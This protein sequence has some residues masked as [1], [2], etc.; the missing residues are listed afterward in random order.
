MLMH[1]PTRPAETLETSSGINGERPHS[2]RTLL[3][4]IEAKREARSLVSIEEDD[5][6]GSGEQGL[7]PLLKCPTR[8]PIRQTSL[9]TIVGTASPAT[10][11]RRRIVETSRRSCIFYRR[12]SCSRHAESGIC[13]G[14]GKVP[15]LNIGAGG[16][17]TGVEILGQVC[18]RSDNIDLGRPLFAE[19]PY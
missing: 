16:Y 4:P 3:G 14:K 17:A 9:M 1:A 2:S 5:F 13:M 12:A 8:V 19:I 7:V 6:S 11:T 18:R 15:N 10:E